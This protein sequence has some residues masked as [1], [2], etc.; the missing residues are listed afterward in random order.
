MADISPTTWATQL[1]TAYTQG[2]QTQ[3]TQQTTL[4]TNTSKA[5]S[6]LKSALSTFSSML[7][8]LSTKKTLQANS[9]TVSDST[10]GTAT[11]SGSAQAG[12]YSFFVQQLAT[13]HQVRYAGIP[14]VTASGAGSLVINQAGGGSFMV[15]LSTA[16]SDGDSAV[17]QTELAR[18][19][20]SAANGSVTASVVTVSGTSYL[21]LTA[22]DTGVSGAIT[23]DTSGVTDG[24]LVTA[25]SSGTELSA[26]QDAIFKIGNEADGI[27]VQ[28]ASNTY[29]GITGLGVTFTKAMV[30]GDTPMSVT[31]A[32]DTSAIND[33]VKKFVDAYNTLRTKLDELTATSID[34]NAR[35]VFASD[36]GVRSLKNSL[37]GI[38][39]KTFGGATLKELGIEA[40]RY[41]KLSIDNEKLKDVLTT[42]PTMLDDVFGYATTATS[43]GVL[44]AMDTVLDAWTESTKGQITRR[45]AIVDK[46]QQNLQTR[47]TRLETQF[48]TMYQRYLQQFTQ[49]QSLTSQ[50]QNTSGLFDQ[51]AA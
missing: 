19:I 31:V 8:S 30:N 5:L 48:N 15:D 29:S 50:L 17:S 37:N 27:T 4:A 32:T 24:S 33:K 51:A 44:G 14:S 6:S 46:Q 9:A 23:L 10:L 7:G 38:L 42:D 35:G 25:L 11:A 2:T 41:G 28:Q 49:L 18:A 20:N 36:A 1:A 3:I 45:K 47:Q 43:S 22:K 26:A 16:D 12:S 21:T 39:R 34:S 13:A 40:D